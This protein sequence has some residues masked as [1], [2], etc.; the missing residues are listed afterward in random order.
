MSD[1]TPANPDETGIET[2]IGQWVED[3]ADTGRDAE[4][5]AR[6]FHK[7]LLHD[8]PDEYRAWADGE[9]TWQLLCDEVV[10]AREAR[11]EWQ[12]RNRR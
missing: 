5:A 2:Q 9:P 6:N 7:T 10:T 3:V 11:A 4:L 1:S 12:R 8:R